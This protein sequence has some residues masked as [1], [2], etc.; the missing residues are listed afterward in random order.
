MRES[1]KLL[2]LLGD[3]SSHS[4]LLMRDSVRFSIRARIASVVRFAFRSDKLQAAD[5]D[6]GT[7]RG[8]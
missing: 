5:A 1:A 6:N 3:N 8:M 4:S 2:T 7:I